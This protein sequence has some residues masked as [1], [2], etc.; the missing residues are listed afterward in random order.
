[1]FVAIV[2]LL[3]SYGQ[4]RTDDRIIPFLESHERIHPIA[5]ALLGLVP[6]CGGAI[7]AVPLYI[8]G[9]VSFGT[10]VAALA[11]T[12]G[13]SA[14]VLLALAP[15]AAVYVY[16]LA[17]VA[18]VTFG[19]AID[20]WGLGVGRVD[21]AINRISQPFADG[22]FATRRVAGRGPGFPPPDRDQ[23]ERDHFSGRSDSGLLTTLTDGIFVLWWIAVAAG[24]IAIGWYLFRGGPSVVL[25]VAP[26]F[27]GLFT[28]AGLIG[29]PASFYL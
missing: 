16:G 5:G 28:V 25:E 11:A 7:I 23:S 9:T 6:G 10:V 14:F 29:V 17:F 13:D 12:A 18:A 15:E 19:Y 1:M 4:F 22:G 27:S 21:S 3:F 2:V 20:V 24:L 8:R 26:T